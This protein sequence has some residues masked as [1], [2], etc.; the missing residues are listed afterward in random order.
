MEMRKTVYVTGQSTGSTKYI[1]DYATVA[2]DATTGAQVWASRYDGGG[3]DWVTG[4]AVSPDGSMVY[5]TGQSQA[6]THGPDEYATVAYLAETGTEVWVSRHGVPNGQ[7]ATPSAIGVS[8]DGSLVF[9]TG[10]SYRYGRTIAYDA[11]TGAGVWS[12]RYGS[13]TGDD[14]NAKVLA[15]ACSCGSVGRPWSSSAVLLEVIAAIVAY[16][17]CPAPRRRKDW[18][19]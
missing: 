18:C 6:A 13:R 8:P 17:P 10:D 5:V 19:R 9:V 15:A 7:D 1:Y 4:L 12:R 2:Y 14:S 11:A 3:N 16:P